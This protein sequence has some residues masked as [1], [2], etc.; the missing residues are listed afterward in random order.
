MSTTLSKLKELASQKLARDEQ[1]TE[2][3][4]KTASGYRLVS[5]TTG[6][7]LGDFTTLKAAKQ[8]EREVQAF[9]HMKQ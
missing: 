1:L 4:V 6:K 8:H 7:N 3:I 9:K 2:H 5:K